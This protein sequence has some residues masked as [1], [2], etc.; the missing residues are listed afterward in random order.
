[1]ADDRER[2][3]SLFEESARLAES[4]GDQPGLIAS[5][6]NRAIIAL[7][8]SEHRRAAD[9]FERDASPSPGKQATSAC[10]PSPC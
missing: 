3:A 1:M 4:A 9:E 5:L 2:A 7:E 10:A 6:N 8:A